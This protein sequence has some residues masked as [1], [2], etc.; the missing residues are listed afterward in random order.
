MAMLV[1][2]HLG[3]LSENPPLNRCRF[4]SS[5]EDRCNPRKP[6]RLRLNCGVANADQDVAVVEEFRL[7]QARSIE[8]W[9]KMECGRCVLLNCDSANGQLS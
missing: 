7:T 8:S 4:I 9:E 5:G 3:M 6:E 2:L 1:A